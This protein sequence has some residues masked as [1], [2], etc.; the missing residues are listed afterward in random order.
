MSACGRQNVWPRCHPTRRAR[1]RARWP[2]L[3]VR[4]STRSRWRRSLHGDLRDAPPA[5][6]RTV[7]PWC[8]RA[9]ARPTA[10]TNLPPKLRPPSSTV[11]QDRRRLVLSGEHAGARTR[12]AAGCSS[13][14]RPRR[15]GR[16]GSTARRPLR[17]AGAPRRRSR[18]SRGWTTRVSGGRRHGASR[19][20]P[21]CRRRGW[22]RRAPSTASSASALQG[23]Y[24][25]RAR[26]DA[27]RRRQPCE[28][29]R[30]STRRSATS[31]R[32][33]CAAASRRARR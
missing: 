24:V 21:T 13:L 29:V 19:G 15:D 32:P 20:A 7:P 2:S 18:R 14:A 23:A 8:S 6:R 9:Y 4:P 25:F 33:S 5:P 28:P 26:R 3:R 12:A 11:N 16:E 31:C 1:E 27:D 22:R 10:A 17:R 30:R